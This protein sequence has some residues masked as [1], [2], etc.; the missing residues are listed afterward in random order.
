MANPYRDFP[1]TPF[2]IVLTHKG[3]DQTGLGHNRHVYGAGMYARTGVFLMPRYF[4]D[5]SDGSD[6]RDLDGS[7][8]PDLD[9]AKIEAV[10]YS[11]EILREMPERVIESRAW[12]MAVSDDKRE[13]LFTLRFTVELAPVEELVGIDG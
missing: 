4:F 5:I 9:A 1:D 8:W 6:F 7:E 2:H 11:A 3:L 13:H 12:K 10:R